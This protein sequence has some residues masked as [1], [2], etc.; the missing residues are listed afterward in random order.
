[1][2]VTGA[3]FDPAATQVEIR[4]GAEARVTCLRYAPKGTHR[5]QV[6]PNSLEIMRGVK[7]REG[8]RS[9]AT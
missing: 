7:E 2:I 9:L 8:I 1:M 4:P 5:V 6:A 3:R